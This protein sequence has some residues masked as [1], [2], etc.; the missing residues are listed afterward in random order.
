MPSISEDTNMRKRTKHTHMYVY[1]QLS[2]FNKGWRCAR[3]YCDHFLP[4]NVEHMIVGRMSLCT[5]CSEEFR[6]DETEVQKAM[7]GDGEPKCYD[8]KLTPEEKEQ[9][10]ALRKYLEQLEEEMD[11]LTRIAKRARE[12]IE[13]KTKPKNEPEDQIEVIEPDTPDE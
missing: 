9:R 2:R 3:P 5:G 12:R 4:S 1:Q 13:N 10:A 8:C 7:A 11:P 6:L